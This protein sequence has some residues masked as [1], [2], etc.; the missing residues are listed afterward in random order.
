MREVTPDFGL[1]VGD[2]RPPLGTQFTDA[3]GNAI[4]TTEATAITFTMTSLRDGTTVVEGEA[5]SDVLRT[6]GRHE[7][8]WASGDT[9]IAGD[10]RATFRVTW[11]DGRP[12]TFPNLQH[13]LVRIYD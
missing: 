3:D 1:H 2:Q 5:A 11:D 6:E 7:Y 10:Y 12:E 4:D 13:H 9:D 8:R